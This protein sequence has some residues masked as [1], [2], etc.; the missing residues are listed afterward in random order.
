MSKEKNRVLFVCN[1][2]PHENRTAGSI[3]YEKIIKTYGAGNFLILSSDKLKNIN[4]GAPFKSLTIDLKNS[5]NSRITRRIAKY[6]SFLLYLFILIKWF[7]KKKTFINEINRFKPNTLLICLR[8][9]LMVIIRDLIEELGFKG[10]IVLYDSDTIYPDK[11]RGWFLFKNIELNYNWLVSKS[12]SI[13]VPGEGMR[14]MYRMKNV[15]RIEIIRVPFNDNTSRCS[16]GIKFNNEITV[17]FAGSIYAE[18]TLLT[19]ISSLEILSQKNA[20]LKFNLIIASKKKLNVSSFNFEITQ[21]G[22]LNEIEL[23]KHIDKSS[24]AYVPYSFEK[25]SALQMTFAFPSKIGFYIS[26]G[27]PIFFHGPQ[28]SAV[29][30]FVEKNELGVCCLSNN[31]SDTLKSIENMIRIVRYEKNELNKKIISSYNTDFSNKVFSDKLS[32][33]L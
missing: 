14:D 19:F 18:K 27:L 17:F 22:W 21:T 12:S 16:N 11:S 4:T 13:I 29:N 30:K 23:K 24:F 5:Y 1:A 8:G 6:F 31:T 2:F 32:N 25:K 7:V 20:S 28:Y 3:F 15:N 9:N 33:L 10:N 26:N